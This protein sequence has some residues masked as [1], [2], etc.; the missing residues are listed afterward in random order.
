MEQLYLFWRK[1]H[2]NI[3]INQCNKFDCIHWNCLGSRFVTCKYIVS[4]FFSF[5]FFLFFQISFCCFLFTTITFFPKQN[6]KIVGT[7]EGV[8]SKNTYYNSVELVS[9]ASPLG[10]FVGGKLNTFD[11]VSRPL[12][13]MIAGVNSHEKK[14]KKKPPLI[15]FSFFLL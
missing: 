8:Y 6:K 14:K 7:G 13:S 11:N 1:I 9:G 12:I 15:S 5:S 10:L 2:N 4:L 3:S